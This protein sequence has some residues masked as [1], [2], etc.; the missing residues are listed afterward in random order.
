M[1]RICTGC[2]NPFKS[3]DNKKTCSSCRNRSNKNNT[4]ARENK[5]QC[6]AIAKSGKQ[7]TNGVSPQYNNEYCGKHDPNKIVSD[8]S[9][10]NKARRDKQN[11]IDKQRRQEI[12]EKNK[13]ARNNIRYCYDCGPGKEH[14]I[15]NM[16]VL[17]D[18]TVS[19]KCKYHFGKQQD[20][21]INRKY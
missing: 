10:K 19:N 16:G 17:R 13:N 6:K 11:E 14:D 4:I 12:I 15:D 8:N 9:E 21:E 18:G 3:T 2:H 7:C 20:R 5:I 1:S